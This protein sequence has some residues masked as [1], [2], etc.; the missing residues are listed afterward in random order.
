[1]IVARAAGV[2]ALTKPSQF[3]ATGPEEVGIIHFRMTE[4]MLRWNLV[5]L[6]RGESYNSLG[7]AP[8]V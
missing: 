3:T 7:T 5:K 4:V 6:L 1:M 8:L 2:S